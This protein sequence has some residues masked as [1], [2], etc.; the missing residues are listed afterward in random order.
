M[1]I[2]AILR[3]LIFRLASYIEYLANRGHVQ[4]LECFQVAK[5]I[6][7]FTPHKGIRWSQLS[8]VASGI[9]NCVEVD[10]PNVVT[11]YRVEFLQ[12]IDKIVNSCISHFFCLLKIVYNSVRYQLIL[13]YSL[14]N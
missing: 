11:L 1:I 9:R 12:L 10:Y 7:L 14:H 13:Y 6:V 3:G 4:R 5:T 2:S 8:W